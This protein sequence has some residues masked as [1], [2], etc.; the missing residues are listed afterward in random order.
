V[1]SFTQPSTDVA[2]LGTE[3]LALAATGNGEGASKQLL[4][5]R[6][7]PGQR[8][9]RFLLLE[10]KELD[11][12]TSG[13]LTRTRKCAAASSRNHTQPIIARDAIAASATFDRYSLIRRHGTARQTCAISS[14]HAAV[15]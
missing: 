7:A 2:S 14:H 12:T 1:I 13:E 8:I 15:V 3:V 5:P 10:F 9:S 11:A 6:L 4:M